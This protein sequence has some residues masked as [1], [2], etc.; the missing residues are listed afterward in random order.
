MNTLE[1]LDRLVAFPTVSDRTN[2][3]LIDFARGLL[4]ASGFTCRLVP[5]RT[6][7]KANLFASIGPQGP[8]GLLLSAHSDVV[9][10][11]GQA[12][13]TDP[14]RL[15]ARDGRLYGRGTAD[16]KGFL[17]SMLHTAAQAE[18]LSLRRPLHLAISH[19]EEIGCVGV[20]GLIDE[21]KASGFR[22]A[23]CIVGEPTRLQAVVGHKGKISAQATFRGVTG[24]SALAPD[25]LNAIHLA[26]DFVGALRALQER[27]AHTGARDESYGVPYTTVHAGRF[28]GGTALNVVAA[29]AQVDFEIRHLSADDPDAL[30]REVHD[31]AQATLAP[32]R[33]RFPTAAVEVELV[34]RYPGLDATAD[35]PAVR[36][37]LPHAAV[38]GL[39]KVSFG[40]E[41]GLFA[42]QLG[43]P[44][45][46]IG[47][48]DMAQGH[49][50]DEFIAASELERCDRFLSTLLQ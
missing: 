5:D 50:P 24:H 49:Q 48:G 43:I 9:P 6:G 22:A 32:H 42:S 46:I 44:S 34:N 28:S 1:I 8:D 7:Q 38:P 37:V 45:V 31:L 20:R 13:S 25:Y 18:Q 40:T 30:M 15:T 36:L 21:L 11:D 16:M 27:L 14:F 19:D 2:L 47:P 12:W 39:A 35:D 3:P 29:R 4:E 26:C 10:V 33:A 23:A 41:A 17:A